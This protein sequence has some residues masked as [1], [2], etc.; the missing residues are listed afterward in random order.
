MLPAEQQID[1]YVDD[2]VTRAETRVKPLLPSINERYEF[3]RGNQYA[4]VDSK[5]KL[6]F[7]PTKTTPTGGGK[8]PWLSRTVNN[9]L[10]DIVQ[11]EV[12]AATQRIPSYEVTPTAPDPDKR[13]AAKTSEQVALWGYEAWNNQLTSIKSVY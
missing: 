1:T 6:S 3:W 10:I 12:S 2:R 8:R 9:L 4:Y 7:L 11:H 5:N 13:S